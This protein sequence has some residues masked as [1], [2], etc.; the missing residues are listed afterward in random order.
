MGDRDERG[1]LTLDVGVALL[2]IAEL[3]VG[4]LLEHAG[5]RGLQQIVQELVVDLVVGHPHREL[6]AL[7]QTLPPAVG[8]AVR[9]QAHVV[10]VWVGRREFARPGVRRLSGNCSG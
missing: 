6:H 5:G 3:Q 7:P 10:R 9:I 4:S 1:P 2:V 8:Q